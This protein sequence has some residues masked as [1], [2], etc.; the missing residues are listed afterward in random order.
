[1]RTIEVT[2]DPGERKRWRGSGTGSEWWS[3]GLHSRDGEAA[4]AV[5]AGVKTRVVP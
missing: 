3:A 1:M 4:L 5:N 2:L